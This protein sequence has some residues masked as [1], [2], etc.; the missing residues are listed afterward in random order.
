VSLPLPL[1]LA[2][3][4]LRP[5]RTFLSAVNLLCVLGI[6]IGAATL[7]VVISV[8]SGFDEMWKEKILGF[9][10]HVIVTD[11]LGEVVPDQ[12]EI[13]DRV[14]AL[15]GVQNAVPFVQSMVVVQHRNRIQAPFLRG[16]DPERDDLLRHPERM[17]R[18]GRLDLQ[19][20]Q[21]LVGGDLA[22]LLMAAPGD[23][24]TVFAPAGY[25]AEDELRLPEEYHLAG[26]FEFGMYQID[27][28]F[29]LASLDTARD[30]LGMESGAHGMQVTLDNPLR[31]HLAKEAIAAALGPRYTVRTWMELNETLFGALAVEKRLMFFL[32]A[33]ISVV[34]SFMVMSTLITITV[35]KTREI[36]LL[37]ALG[38]SSARVMAIFLA[39]GL[40]Q[41]VLGLLGGTAGGLLL[42][43]HRNDVLNWASETFGWQLFPKEL[44]FLSDL[45]ARV[46]PGEILFINAVLLAFCLVASLIP[47]WLAARKDPVHALRYE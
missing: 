44:Y 20:E 6:L 27:Q 32:L 45:P 1:Q 39:Y 8:M 28:G 24:L 17:L 9:S 13:Y 29:V 10:P 14:L 12:G 26:I 5:R 15:P 31:A 34:A 18:G 2:L 38:F 33:I 19:G 46:D 23:T 16:V 37:R 41:G 21:V 7:I 3:R 42:L 22:A 36:G 35:Q 47:S 30:L 43:H 11:A 25:S 40:I 4:Y